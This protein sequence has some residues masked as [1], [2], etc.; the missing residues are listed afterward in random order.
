MKAIS[1]DE[2]AAVCRVKPATIRRAH[3][4]N[5]HYLGIQPVKLPNRMLLWP[6]DEVE[7]VTQRTPH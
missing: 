7:R 2:F 5:G 6:A 3:C 4:L 1:T